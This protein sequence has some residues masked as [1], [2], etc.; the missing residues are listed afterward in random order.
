MDKLQLRLKL[1]L[2]S[3]LLHFQLHGNI[4][5]QLTSVDNT[6]GKQP[7]QLLGIQHLLNKKV[8]IKLAK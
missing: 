2:D 1:D 6:D 8:M 7:G 5:D 3:F 4:E